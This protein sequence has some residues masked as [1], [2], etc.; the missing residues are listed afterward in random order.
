[1]KL[2]LVTDEGIAEVVLINVEEYDWEKPLPAAILV[3]NLKEVLDKVEDDP[4]T[5]L[6]KED[7]KD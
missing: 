3:N 2:V 4:N 5:P 7:D 1:M 6:P